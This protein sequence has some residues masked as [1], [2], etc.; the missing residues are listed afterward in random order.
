[1]KIFLRNIGLEQY[2]EAFE[3]NGVTAAN[4]K[5]LSNDDLKDMGI[6]VLI[7]RK[8]IL[9]AIKEEQNKEKSVEKI[10]YNK[11]VNIVNGG[12]ADVKIT[13]HRAI[14]GEKTY[15]LQNIAAVEAF[16]NEEEVEKRYQA[17]LNAWRRQKSSSGSKIF[18]SILIALGFL[19][20]F[21]NMIDGNVETLINGI[22]GAG[23]C[24]F[25]PG[26]ILVTRNVTPAEPIKGNIVWSV[27]IQASGTSSDVIQSINEQTIREI[28]NALNDSIM[29][30]N[31]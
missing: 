8:E 11:Q 22:I 23:I 15:S 13:S 30:L 25:L 21:G 12:V 29:N 31:V 17:A 9:K 5:E 14:L 1:M 7:H 20:I 3:K 26:G 28:V 18:G 27:R 10:F 16:S 19:S 4:L 6:D 2:L 24:C